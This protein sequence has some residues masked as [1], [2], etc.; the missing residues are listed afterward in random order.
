MALIQIWGR[1]IH[2]INFASS[3]DCSVSLWVLRKGFSWNIS[4]AWLFVYSDLHRSPLS[5][6]IQAKVCLAKHAQLL[7]SCWRIHLTCSVGN[8]DRKARL[9]LCCPATPQY[10]MQNWADGWRMLQRTFLSYMELQTS[11][12]STSFYHT[13]QSRHAVLDRTLINHHREAAAWRDFQYVFLHSFAWNRR[14]R[15]NKALLELVMH[16]F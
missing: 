9:P 3:L 6:C 16:I 5:L 11:K 4:N 10:Q 15:L 7:F 1:K 13:H 12:H 8:R 2:T 14:G